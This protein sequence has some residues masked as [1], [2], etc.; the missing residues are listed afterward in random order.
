MASKKQQLLDRYIDSTRGWGFHP[1]RMVR[2]GLSAVEHGVIKSI[3]VP[4]HIANA[5]YD[6]VTPKD[7]QH[8]LRWTPYGLAIR[9]GVKLSPLAKAGIEKYAKWGPEGMVFRGAE[10]ALPKI[11]KREYK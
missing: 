6:K 9:A 2:K 1:F 8:I 7:L 5:A 4:Y 11:A 3:E 10:Y